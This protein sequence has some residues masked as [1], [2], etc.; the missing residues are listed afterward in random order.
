M[1][2][3]DLISTHLARPMTHRV[4]T[5]YECGKVRTFDVRSLAQAENHA[6][7]ERRKIGKS[8]I[9]RMTGATVRVIAVTIDAI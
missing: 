5:V 8:L 4:T 3:L 2:A 1:N 7:G 6:T 9:D